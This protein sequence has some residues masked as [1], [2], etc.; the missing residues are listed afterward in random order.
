MSALDDAATTFDHDRA[1]ER[2]L[3]QK[4][5]PG[6]LAADWE[7]VTGPAPELDD[8]ED[9]RLAGALAERSVILLRHD[10]LLPPGE[11]GPARIAVLGCYSFAHHVQPWESAGVRITTGRGTGVEASNSRARDAVVPTRLLAFTG[12]D[13]RR[14]LDGSEPRLST[15][16]VSPVSVSP[17]THAQ[18]RAHS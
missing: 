16:P 8:A 5:E 11:A 3:R 12:R 7:P 1:V 13:G 15:V 9:R 18:G 10:G 4:A 6:P 2:V 17:L 14:V